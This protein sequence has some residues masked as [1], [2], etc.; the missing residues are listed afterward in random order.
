MKEFPRMVIFA[1]LFNAFSEETYKKLALP[2][3]HG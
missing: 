3:E 1:P 2:E